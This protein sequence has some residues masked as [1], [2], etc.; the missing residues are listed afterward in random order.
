MIIFGDPI[1]VLLP[2]AG[3]ATEKNVFGDPP[4]FCLTVILSILILTAYTV[5]IIFTCENY[6]FIRFLPLF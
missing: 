2:V 6:H 3:G 1:P 4:R 5:Y